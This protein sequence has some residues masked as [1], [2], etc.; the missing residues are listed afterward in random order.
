[1]KD[2]QEELN[3]GYSLTIT[4]LYELLYG[5]PLLTKREQKE[6]EEQEFQALFFQVADRL[7]EEDGID[8]QHEGFRDKT[9]NWFHRLQDA[10]EKIPGYKMLKDNMHR[11]GDSITELYR[12]MKALWVLLMED[13]IFDSI[14]D[15]N[16][17]KIQLPIF[18]NAVSRDPH[19]L[20]KNRGAGKLF[21][22]ALKFVYE[23]MV[24]FGVLDDIINDNPPFMRDRML[25]RQFGLQDD[26]I[27]S[28]SIYQLGI[29]INLF[30]RVP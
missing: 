30:R 20:D 21:L 15:V 1:M 8:I 10:A 14:K 12:C 17:D 27:S 3:R 7:L 19:A 29:C 16:K 5:K 4:S 13:Q 26:D 6:K 2:I 9:Y 11:E 18:A 24:L 23:Q 28:F 25:Y 22:R